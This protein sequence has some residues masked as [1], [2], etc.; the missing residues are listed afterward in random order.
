MT[1]WVGG[2]VRR[3]SGTRESGSV[4]YAG[5]ARDQDLI[6]QQKLSG[7]TG[8]VRAR[9]HNAHVEADTRAKEDAQKRKREEMAE[10]RHRNW[11]KRT[12]K[13]Q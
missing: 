3:A 10:M 9:I 12:Y 5:G 7:T 13:N 2:I 4:R 6:K 1:R 8:N 11:R